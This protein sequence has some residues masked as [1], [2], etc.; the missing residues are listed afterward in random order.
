MTNQSGRAR[1]A[2]GS[3]PSGGQ[4]NKTGLYTAIMWTGGIA[5][6]LG[7]YLMLGSYSSHPT[8]F[9]TGLVL[10]VF[11][12]SAGFVSAIVRSIIRNKSR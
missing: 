10:L 5:A 8:Q 4:P 11:G 9:N 6:L 2:P 1:S 3:R 12:G 7:F